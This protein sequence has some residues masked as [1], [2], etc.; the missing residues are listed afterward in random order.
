MARAVNNSAQ[1]SESLGFLGRVFKGLSAG[2]VLTNIAQADLEKMGASASTQLQA[3]AESAIANASTNMR[4]AMRGILSNLNRDYED[5]NKNMRDQ[6]T[7]QIGHIYDFNKRQWGFQKTVWFNLLKNMT[8]SIKKLTVGIANFMKGALDKIGGFW[9]WIL[10]MA[11]KVTDFFSVN[12]YNFMKKKIGE[13]KALMLSIP[14]ATRALENFKK[15]RDTV[16]EIGRGIGMQPEAVKKMTENLVAMGNALIPSTKYLE[17][18][19]AA[20]NAGVR[21]ALT[22]AALENLTR[23]SQ[24]TGT[25]VDELT[26][27]YFSLKRYGMSD[28]E[29]YRQMNEINWM[30]RLNT[31]AGLDYGATFSQY[32]QTLEAGMEQIALLRS[33]GRVAEAENLRRNLLMARTAESF[34]GQEGFAS[35]IQSL[36]TSTDT[37]GNLAGGAYT[38]SGLMMGEG[39]LF[40]LIDNLV[41]MV[42]GV[43]AVYSAS[44]DQMNLYLQRV[45]T[46]MGV[47]LDPAVIQKLITFMPQLLQSYGYLDNAT[48]LALENSDSFQIQIEGLRTPAELL[49]ITLQDLGE[50]IMIGDQSLGDFLEQF[51]RFETVFDQVAGGLNFFSGTLDFFFGPLSELLKPLAAVATIFMVLGGIATNEDGFVLDDQFLDSLGPLGSALKL[52]RDQ[53]GGFQ[54]MFANLKTF[55]IDFVNSLFSGGA[56]S[57]FSQMITAGV[58]FI[59]SPEVMTQIN[60]AVEGFLMPFVA[61]LKN[62]FESLRKNPRFVQG[63]ESLFN[64][65]V[66]TLKTVMDSMTDLLVIAVTTLVT[67]L[68]SIVTSGSILSD[69]LNLAKAIV[70]ALLPAFLD[71][72]KAIWEGISSKIDPDSEWGYFFGLADSVEDTT[73]G[74][75]WVSQ[76]AMRVAMP[77]A[78]VAHAVGLTDFDPAEIDE[79]IGQTFADA[80][81]VLGSIFKFGTGAFITAPVVGVTGEAGPEVISPLDSFFNYSRNLVTQAA[82]MSSTDIQRLVEEHARVLEQNKQVIENLDELNSISE[83][84]NEVMLT[85]EAALQGLSRGWG[86]IWLSNKL[87]PT[88][89][90]VSGPAPTAS[91]RFVGNLFLQ[92]VS[93]LSSF[94]SETTDI[95]SRTTALGLPRY[96]RRGEDRFEPFVNPETG[97]KGDMTGYFQPIPAGVPTSYTDVFDIGTEA[98]LGGVPGAAR[99]GGVRPHEGYDF[100][101]PIGTKLKAIF[102]GLIENR[103]SSRSGVGGNQL[104]LLTDFGI[105]ILYAHL[106]NNKGAQPGDI[107]NAGDEIAESGIQGL[108]P[109]PHLHIG[110]LGYDLADIWAG[111]SLGTPATENIEYRAA[112]GGT[113]IRDSIKGTDSTALV[114]VSKLDMTT[115]TALNVQKQS[116]EK[117]ASAIRDGIDDL[118]A[119]LDVLQSSIEST[120]DSSF[121][122]IFSK[123]RGY[124]N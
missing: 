33:T 26:R 13:L 107:V 30:L 117:V 77:Q 3:G 113:I 68:I 67:T 81:T 29:I 40:T 58:N 93:L 91:E 1:A 32:L 86:S 105:R 60:N 78:T 65:M 75:N 90:K 17:T 12:I 10:N 44:G 23:V 99:G 43:N 24:A 28:D 45:L 55:F 115:K 63:I 96:R 109:A 79:Y 56:N 80:G 101:L 54:Q 72:G 111:A 51:E 123:V 41:T 89:I 31:E 14:G 36:T 122:S 42:G 11:K 64:I 85:T 120:G 47:T 71:I 5:F 27:V 35:L 25:S 100:W 83:E 8:G 121:E 52:L 74:S 87:T 2:S 38:I 73:P 104:V 97:L 59:T 7:K 19:Q 106:N 98:V 118:L 50:N 16:Y 9:S 84:R 103:T 108:E 94:V 49:E 46:E 110:A 92:G 102:P 21:G 37:L 34:L 20:M 62:M 70:D 6:L 15:I 76:T 39:G 4:G 112:K 88:T 119:M 61:G 95:N 69:L 18:L 48:Q 124:V 114:P 22:P 66:E 57:K 82:L 116:S 53:A